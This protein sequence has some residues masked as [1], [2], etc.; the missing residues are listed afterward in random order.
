MRHRIAMQSRDALDKSF[1]DM[2]R[3]E[4]RTR[5]CIDFQE[6]NRNLCAKKL[7]AGAIVN[8]GSWVDSRKQEPLAW[9]RMARD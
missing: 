7:R 3:H 6:R 9:A 2:E 1:V 8:L 4:G 5:R